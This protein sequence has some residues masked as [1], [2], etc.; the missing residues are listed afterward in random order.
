MPTIEDLRAKAN[1]YRD[2]TKHV[3]DPRSLEAMQELASELDS[4][5]DALEN[6]EHRGK[7]SVPD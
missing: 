7:F 6:E 4:Q 3:T 2:M 5:A 1:H